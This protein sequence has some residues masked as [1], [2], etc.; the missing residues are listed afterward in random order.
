V[1]ALAMAAVEEGP[2]AGVDLEL[3]P[4]Q[5]AWLRG[6]SG[7]G[8]TLLLY[9]A[10]GLRVPAAGS[11]TVNGSQPGPGRAA[12]LFQNPDYQLL[13]ATVGA[14]VRLNAASPAAAAEALERTGSAAWAETGVTALSPGQRRITALAGVL[15]TEAPLLLLDTPFAGMARGEA[16]RLWSAARAFALERDAAVLAT[17]E[18]PRDGPADPTLE[19]ELWHREPPSEPPSSS[20]P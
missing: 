3:A 8:K 12:M 19:V 7:S 16:E 4:G 20:I 15:A 1:T 2:L 6:P 10:A 5:I 11:V 17:G 14:D 9:V 18:P 13:A